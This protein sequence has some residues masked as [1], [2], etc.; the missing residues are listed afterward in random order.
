MRE[1][2]SPERRCGCWWAGGGGEE[3]STSQWT[4]QV[5]AGPEVRWTGTLEATGNRDSVEGER[6]PKGR[7][8]EGH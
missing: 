8:G 4:K 5:N 3:A 1:R 7:C 2:K 6:R